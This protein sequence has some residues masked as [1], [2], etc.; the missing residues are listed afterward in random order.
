MDIDR[1]CDQLNKTTGITYWLL[2]HAR[3]DSTTI[4][5]LP[6]LYS[7]KCG[8]VISSPNP[9]PREV[10]SS[11]AETA[12]VTLFSR[13]ASSGKDWLGDATAQIT[14][15]S[16]TGLDALIRNLLANCRTQQN[17]LFPLPGA[18]EPYPM[19]ELA[20][21]SIL[22]LSP[23]Q[24]LECAQEFS[25]RILSAASDHPDI[26]VS[27]IELF[28]TR[29]HLTAITSAGVRLIYPATRLAAEVCLLCRPDDDHAGEHTAR[30]SARRLTDLDP[31]AIV[32][33]TAPLARQLALA[34]PAPTWQGKVLLLGE[35]AADFL[36]TPNT[37]LA[38]H[39][40]ARTVY[41]KSSRYSAGS[42][43]S[44]EAELKGEPLNLKSDPTIDFGLSSQRISPA[45][46]SACRTATLVRDGCWAD[47]LGTR[48]YFCYLGLLDKGILPP[49]VVG[50]TVVPAGHT[51]ISELLGE[52]CAVVKAFSGFSLDR[53]SGQFSVEI[54]LGELRR[55]GKA[56]PFHG[57][58]LVGNWFSAI[59][60]ARYSREVQARN[61]Y[62]GPKA[63]LFGNLQLA[64]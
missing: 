31:A 24:L 51:P 52:E 20:D 62:F 17:P 12:T 37:P 7:I 44:G 4:I 21:R 2:Q 41:E 55:G 26:T 59:A 64:G 10:I 28:F 16:E 53:T 61:G 34:G 27:N 22:D 19:V 38:F 39:A 46:G 30:L 40:S 3:T 23:P 42:P 5:H 45:D 11:P 6:T 36:L 18:D 50:N 54:R 57:G 1:I 15:D 25:S 56:T 35:A 33:E 29:S 43:V 32:A 60:D 63:I 14:D 8:E 47:L 13:F 58:L 48:R 9:F 49:G